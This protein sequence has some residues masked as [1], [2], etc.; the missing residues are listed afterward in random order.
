MP[1]SDKEDP[2]VSIVLKCATV[3]CEHFCLESCDSFVGSD[4]ST[5]KLST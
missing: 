4:S 5:K 2:H 3:L 1:Y